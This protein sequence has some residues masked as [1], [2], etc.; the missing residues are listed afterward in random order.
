MKEAA[1]I[2]PEKEASEATRSSSEPQ[3]DKRRRGDRTTLSRSVADALRRTILEGPLAQGDKLESAAEMTKRYKVSRTVIREAIASLQ[4]DGL[5]ESRQGAGVFVLSTR[6]ASQHFL[7][8]L[9]KEKISKVVE[10]LELRLAVEVEA[11]ALAAA[12]RSPAQEHAIWER[13]DELGACIEEGRP[14]APADLA[15]HIAC[16]DATNNPRFREFLEMI[17]ENVIP[18]ASLAVALYGS[19]APERS[20][21][22]YLRQIQGEHREIAEAISAGA[23]EAAR[24]A[25]RTHLKGSLERYRALIRA[26]SGHHT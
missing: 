15:F 9:E 1:R 26:R 23:P 2:G 12:R 21:T 4:A 11:G 8:P 19:D 16:A 10:M 22:S 14:T 13:H 24:A 17:G 7:Q 20:A 6:A 3:G 5:V 25:V 18:R